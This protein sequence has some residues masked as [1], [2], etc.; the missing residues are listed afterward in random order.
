[1]NGY[2]NGRGWNGCLTVPRQLSFSRDGQLQQS[3]A[4]QLEKLRGKSVMRK[5][6]RLENSNETF[7]LPNTNSLEIL[8]EIDL[9]TAKRVE[10]EFKS[11]ARDV[12]PLIVNF[13]GSQLTVMGAKAPLQLG[14][15]RKLNLRVFLDRSM[16]EVFANETVCFTKTVLPMDTSYTLNV[17]SDGPANVKQ[18]RAWPMK[19]IW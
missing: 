10:L 1:M 4:P 15:D 12:R 14:S 17:R 19:T 8:A 16:M 6:I 9:K 5:N 2:P 11:G 13:D 18:L 3:P 7:V